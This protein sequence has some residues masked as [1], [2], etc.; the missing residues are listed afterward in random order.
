MVYERRLNSGVDIEEELRNLDFDGGIRV[1]GRY[2]GEPCFIFVTKAGENFIAAVYSE[3]R[4][5]LG[6][7]VPDRRLMLKRY[8]D[9]SSLMKFL[10]GKTSD[11]LEAY[12]Y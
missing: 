7:E 6:A 2:G 10:E 4:G 11:P 1:R 12:S 5:R 3:K 8:R 9:M